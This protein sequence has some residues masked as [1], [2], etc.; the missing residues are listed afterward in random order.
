MLKPKNSNQNWVLQG[1]ISPWRWTFSSLVGITRSK[2]C[3]LR[4][5]ERSSNI[6]LITFLG[7]SVHLIQCKKTSCQHFCSGLFLS[8]FQKGFDRV[9]S[10]TK[11]ASFYIFGH[12]QQKTMCVVLFQKPTVDY[13]LFCFV[14]DDRCT[15]KAKAQPTKAAFI[16]FPL[17]RMSLNVGLWKESVYSERIAEANEDSLSIVEERDEWQEA[18]W[19][20]V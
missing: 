5:I 16:I 1:Q 3:W 11:I 7:H 19:G 15:R 9:T 6:L 10:M 18:L 12:P 4:V 2:G 17:K 20:A 14:L 13:L 8:K